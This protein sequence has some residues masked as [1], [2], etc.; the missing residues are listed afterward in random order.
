MPR[1]N[2]ERLWLSFA[3]KLKSLYA[4]REAI[5]HILIEAERTTTLIEQLLALA[6]ADAGR[7]S[8]NVQ[9][10]DLRPTL[11]GVVDAWQQLASIR[12]LHF[13]ANIGDQES[14][15]MA[16][17]ALLRRVIAILLDNAFKYTPAPGKVTLSLENGG[18]MAIVAVQ[19]SGVGIAPEDQSKIFERFYRV[20]KAR[21]RAQG[22]TGLGL[23]I[24]QWIATQHGGSITVESRPGEGSTFRLQLPKI[25]SPERKLVPSEPY[26]NSRP[27]P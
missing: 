16:D 5:R 9:A 4:G 3:P 10:V 25:A 21:S 26:S 19:D 2:Y 17:E 24:A 27:V 1:T 20:D 8:L 18:E 15:V 23:S 11:Q 6:R 12:T 22:G 13:S 7:E 14:F